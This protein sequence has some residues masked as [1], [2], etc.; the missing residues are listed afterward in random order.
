MKQ[1]LEQ[2]GRN[3]TTLKYCK[4]VEVKVAIKYQATG[5]H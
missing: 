1:Y 5:L 4:N 3:E 2:S